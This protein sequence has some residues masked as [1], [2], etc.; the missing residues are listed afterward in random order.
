MKH[1]HNRTFYSASLIIVMINF[2]DTLFAW[3]HARYF[4]EW[5]QNPIATY[6]YKQGGLLPVLS[7]K[8]LTL[9]VGLVIMIAGHQ[10]AKPIAFYGM[11]AL[12]A[13]HITLFLYYL[14]SGG[15]CL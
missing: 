14:F 5:E 4:E 8:L 13:V 12:C 15:L 6:I 11:L 9:A 2:Y 3:K 1:S 7:I 10:R